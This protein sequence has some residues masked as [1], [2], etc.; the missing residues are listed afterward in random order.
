MFNNKMSALKYML[1]AL[2][3]WTVLLHCVS[4]TSSKSKRKACMQCWQLNPYFHNSVDPND[5]ASQEELDAVERKV[6]ELYSQLH[7][8]QNV[9]INILKEQYFP[10]NPGTLNMSQAAQWLTQPL[11]TGPVSECSDL[12]TL[13]SAVLNNITQSSEFNN[14]PSLQDISSLCTL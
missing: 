5:C 8:W 12:R 2:V 4:G 14:C 3:L 10:S 7:Y 11:I 13:E 1:F 6:D 9:T